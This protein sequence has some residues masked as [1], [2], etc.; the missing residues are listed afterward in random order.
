MNKKIKCLGCGRKKVICRKNMCKRCYDISRGNYWRHKRL[1]VLRKFKL[2]IPQYEELTKKCFLC[3]W[4]YNIIPHHILPKSKGGKT[5]FSNLIGLCPN[6]H[7]RIHYDLKYLRMKIKKICAH[8]GI[9]VP[10]IF[11]TKRLTALIKIGD[12]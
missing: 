7:A 3:R 1:L 5:T 6:H 4:K 9:P 11:Y 8:K 2:T 10:P 12:I